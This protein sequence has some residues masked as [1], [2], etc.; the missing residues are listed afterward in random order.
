MRSND[1][2]LILIIVLVLVFIFLVGGLSGYGMMGYRPFGGG[3]MMGCFS[4]FGFGFMWIFMFI[5]W[6]LFIILLVL[7]ILWLAKQLQSSTKHKEVKGGRK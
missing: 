1:N 3:M 4:P 2:N 7:G 6:V 5:I